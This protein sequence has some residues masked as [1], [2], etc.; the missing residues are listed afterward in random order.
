ML[1]LLTLDNLV[2]MQIECHFKSKWSDS[3]W[4]TDLFSSGC[5]VSSEN[6]VSARRASGEVCKDRTGSNIDLK[7]QK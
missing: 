1:L 6:E 7:G 3:D 4:L 2:N 5:N